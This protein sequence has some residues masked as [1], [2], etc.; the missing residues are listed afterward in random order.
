MKK[1]ETVFQL[2]DIVRET[3]FALHNYL[4]NGHVEKVYENALVHRLRKQGLHVVAQHP[5]AVYDEDNTPL[6]EFYADLF[7]ENILIVELKAVRHIADE[8][9]AQLLGYLRCSRVEHGL[10]MNFGAPRFYVKKYI[11]NDAF[12]DAE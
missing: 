10:L 8:H 3:G 7:I 1:W 6:G 5:L 12:A 11:L 9:V 4:R 2:C